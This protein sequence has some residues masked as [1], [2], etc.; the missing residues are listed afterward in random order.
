MSYGDLGG[1]LIRELARSKNDCPPYDDTA[2]REIV[3]ET[4]NL[5]NKNRDAYESPAFTRIQ[6][7]ETLDD[8]DPDDRSVYTNAC[9]R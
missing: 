1:E 5:T 7:N 9:I 4:I 3:E 6:N 2:V 8:V